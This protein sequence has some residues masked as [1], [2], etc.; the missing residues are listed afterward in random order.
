M[1]KMGIG[2]NSNVGLHFT[3]YASPVIVKIPITGPT[4]LPANIKSS[5]FFDHM[6]FFLI[7]AQIPRDRM[8]R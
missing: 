3:L 6:V 4:S 2:F 5:A 1:I 8:M 7:D